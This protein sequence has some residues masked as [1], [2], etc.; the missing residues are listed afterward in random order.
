MSSTPTCSNCTV[1]LIRIIYRRLTYFR[2]LENY[3]TIL[4]F[5]CVLYCSIQ[6][7]KSTLFHH[8]G[9]QQYRYSSAFPFACR[10]LGARPSRASRALGLLVPAGSL[11]LCLFIKHSYGRHQYE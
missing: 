9:N 5:T 4:L 7:C 6:V 3:T 11:G 2:Q 8:Y 1:A 10:A